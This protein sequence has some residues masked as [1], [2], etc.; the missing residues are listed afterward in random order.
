M[1]DGAEPHTACGRCFLF[2][3]APSGEDLRQLLDECPDLIP[4]PPVAGKFL[5]PGLPRFGEAG[6]IVEADVN[7]PGFAGKDG[8]ALPGVAA[9]G[10]HIIK[11]LGRQIRDQFGFLCGNI[12]SGF[13]HH[14]DGIRIQTVRFDSG[15]IRFDH[16]AFQR[17]RPALRHLAAAAVAG[18][19]KQDFHHNPIPYCFS[20]FFLKT[21]EMQKCPL[22]FLFGSGE[23][24]LFRFDGGGAGGKGISKPFN[25][26]EHD[27]KV[28]LKLV[29]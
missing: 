18:T 11:L 12:H 3:S 10:D 14:L 6:G 21:M 17:A 13:G 26:H 9:D 4:H 15:G 19:E 16:I 8:A 25:S 7:D 24:G 2:R 1:R 23:I 29:R 28:F 5:L 27:T 22:P 20:A